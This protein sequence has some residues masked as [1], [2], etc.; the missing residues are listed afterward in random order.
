MDSR[1]RGN[2]VDSG[3]PG[4]GETPRFVREGNRQARQRPRQ[5]AGAPATLTGIGTL[6]SST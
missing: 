5:C 2:D 1:L 4:L 6:Q 3:K